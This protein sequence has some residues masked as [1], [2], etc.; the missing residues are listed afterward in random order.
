MAPSSPPLVSAPVHQH[1]FNVRLDM[2]VDG[3][4]N[5]VYEVRPR[6]TTRGP[7]NP[8]GNAF[9]AEE[10]LLRTELEARRERR[11]AARPLLARS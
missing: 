4:A 2:T 9:H 7:A 8:Y 6:P 1:F 5:S 10:R 3:T 11:P